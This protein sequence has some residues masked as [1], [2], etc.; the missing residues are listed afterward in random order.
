MKW[1][2]LAEDHQALGCNTHI[3]KLK[4]RCVKTYENKAKRNQDRKKHVH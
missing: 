4:H 1:Q 2:G 3:E